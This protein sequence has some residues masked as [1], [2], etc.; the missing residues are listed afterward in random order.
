MIKLKIKD[1]QGRP[2][3][4]KGNTLYVKVNGRWRVC[5]EY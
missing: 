4:L 3:A 1:E 5:R 2:L